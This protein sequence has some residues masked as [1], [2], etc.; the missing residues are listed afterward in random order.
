MCV[1]SPTGLGFGL[2]TEI[3]TIEQTGNLCEQVHSGRKLEWLYHLGHGEMVT[4]CFDKTYRIYSSTFQMGL[5]HQVNINTALR[6]LVQDNF[7]KKNIYIFFSFLIV[8]S[9]LIASH[10]L[11]S[12]KC[13]PSQIKAVFFSRVCDLQ[14]LGGGGHEPKTVNHYTRYFVGFQ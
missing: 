5:L 11:F 4:H 2:L 8:H 6:Y 14:S 9:F 10:C 1:P 3:T 7:K 12:L 13:A